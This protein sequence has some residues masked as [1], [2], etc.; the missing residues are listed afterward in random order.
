M[1]AP[2][3]S[4]RALIVEDLARAAE[5]ANRPAAAMLLRRFPEDRAA[6]AVVADDLRTAATRAGRVA[7]AAAGY[8]AVGGVRGAI[9]E[10]AD[11]CGLSVD[12]WLVE[13]CAEQ[14]VALEGAV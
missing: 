13:A 14:G 8:L 12:E 9:G 1:S 6:I 7:G 3:V 11:Y 2:V 10:M 5:R 4:R